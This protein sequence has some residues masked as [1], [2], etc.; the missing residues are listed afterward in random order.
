MGNQPSA[1][2]K[3]SEL[4]KPEVI[5]PP[6]VCDA[7]CQRQKKLAGLKNTLDQKTLTKA[8]DPEGY[9]QAR[10]AY[11]TELNGQ[12]WLAEEKQRIANEEVSPK[13]TQYTTQYE[14]LKT[15]QQNQQ[16]FLNLMNAL[17]EEEAQDETDLDYLEKKAN[18]EKD[19]V[20]VLNR[21]AVLNQGQAPVATTNYWP[22][23]LQVAIG[24][25]ALIIVYLIYSKFGTLKSYLGIGQSS[26]V[27]VGGKKSY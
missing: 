12:G 1:P 17:K 13:V 25:L 21:L 6:P 26:P 20:D 10:I 9:E 3:P 18:Q 16:V 15:Q 24:I 5:P 8:T 22:T 27:I 23:I 11:F 19:Q 4:S 7:D 14:Q 2:T